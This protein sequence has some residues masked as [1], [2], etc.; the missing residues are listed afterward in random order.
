MADRIPP[1]TPGSARE[2]YELPDEYGAPL[3]PEHPEADEH[4]RLIG[5]GDEP[6]ANG[7]NGERE[8]VADPRSRQERMQALREA[9][10]RRARKP[11][12]SSG[13]RRARRGI[14]VVL[15][16]VL[17][18]AGWSYLHAL[19]RSGTDSAGVRTVDWI[20]DHGGGSA[21]AAVE[22]W[23]YTNDPPVVGGK[24]TRIV[25][26]SSRATAMPDAAA[27]AAVRH[28]PAPSG[29]VP[30][31]AAH[32]EPNEGV[33][34]PA[35]PPVGGIPAAYTT[36]VRPDAVHTSYWTTLLRL[37]TELLD[38]T[39]VPGLLEP[40]AG[41]N[42]WHSEVPTGERDDLFAA[43]NAGA[44]FDTAN[45]GVYLRGKTVEPLRDGAA[46]FVVDEDGTADVGAW[47]DD[48]SLDG[49][50]VAV[51][52]NG[53]LIVEDG[54]VAAL[55]GRDGSGAF[56]GDPGADVALW[57]SGVGVDRHG[58]VLYAAGPALTAKSLARTLRAAG[59]V[60]AM[61]LDSAQGVSAFLYRHARGTKLHASMTRD[62]DRYLEPGEHDFFAVFAAPDY[63]G[64]SS[65][66]QEFMQ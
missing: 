23:W 54:H 31:P 57:R 30:T 38:T 12:R 15:V 43:F 18:V 14:A 33:W 35:G 2:L 62:P 6:H 7:A 42:P 64:S 17:A 28:L 32:V 21:V 11:A 36:S 61:E 16:V 20:R 24:P 27:L 37:D 65:S 60:R 34:Q 10:D 22:R 63:L 56:A 29:R 48:V 13:V 9:R 41:A 55:P 49:D 51:R 5:P 58:A 8:A 25:P 50:V 44:D 47:N 52:Q 45:G 59:A 4:M 3:H 40:G 39:Y 26:P 46:S 53:T 1:R 66:E 19:T